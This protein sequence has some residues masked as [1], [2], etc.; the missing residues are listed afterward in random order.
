M[1]KTNRIKLLLDL[2]TFVAFLIAMDPRSL[3]IAVHEWLTIA[4]AGTIVVH[5]L[6]NW[7]WIVEVTKR[8]FAKGKGLNG[9][10]VNYILNWAMFIDGVLIM[11][12]GIMISQA[13]MPSMGIV[14]PE[15]FGWRGLHS[16]STNLFMLGLG[17]HVALHWNWIVSTSKRL[18]VRKVK[19]TPVVV[20]SLDRKDVQA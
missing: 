10:R 14:L 11:L 15:S 17:L 3:G 8:L 2:T 19:Q 18:F 16:F 4:L 7:G 12:S 9:S 1:S 13:V 5:L 6:L 20:M